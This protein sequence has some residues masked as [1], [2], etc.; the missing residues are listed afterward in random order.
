MS[1]VIDIDPTLEPKRTL[2]THTS[3]L[4]RHRPP[5]QAAGDR[6]KRK[7]KGGSQPAETLPFEASLAYVFRNSGGKATA[8]NAARLL[9]DDPRFKRLTHAYDSLSLKDQ[10]R[11]RLED[12]CEAAEIT[13]NDFLGAVVPALWRRNVD[14]GKA[15]AAISH[16]KVVEATISNAVNGGTF[17]SGDRRMLFEHIGFLPTKNNG[18]SVTIDNSQKTLVA[19]TLPSFEET[20]QDTAAITRGGGLRASQ[21]YLPDPKQ[22]VPVP[23][24]EIVQ[25]D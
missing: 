19:G 1:S 15:I 13:V 21:R 4:K 17:G 2:P 22:D 10:D 20:I 16:P 6:V 14:I 23:E 9:E 25:S 12:L 11:V 18:F 24:A 8:I 3:G 5:A 7:N